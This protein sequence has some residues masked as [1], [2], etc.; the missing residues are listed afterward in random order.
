MNPLEERLNRLE[1][2]VTRY[3]NFNVLLCLL[4]VTVVT[5]A[6]R[7]G[8][9]PFQ[10]KS[11]SD[12]RA[13]PGANMGVPDS[14]DRG[15]PDV[16]YPEVQ[17]AG[18]LA[19]QT[20]GVIRTRRLEVVNS[21]GEAVVVLTP[22]TK[23]GGL[24][25]VNSA[26][27]KNLVYIGSSASN[28]NGLVLIN[29]TEEKN[30]IALASDSE[31]G[32]GYISI[33][34]RNEVRLLSLFAQEDNPRIHINNAEHRNLAYLGANTSG[35]GLLSLKNKSG[36][37]M[38]SVTAD[39]MSGHLSLMNNNDKTIAYLGTYSDYL[40][41]NSNGSGVLE[42]FSKNGTELITVG[43][44]T[45]DNGLVRGSNNIGTL[46]VALVAA[47]EQG[48]V[49]IQNS[50]ERLLVELTAT[51]VGDGLVRTLSK[52]GITTWSSA[53]FQGNTGS[54][55]LKGD[56]DNDGDIDGDDFLIFSE[57]FGK[58]E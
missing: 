50:Q 26:E 55:S 29:S 24:I 57:N 31:T 38:V 56:M 14:P 3:R 41:T 52:Q 25:F 35:N 12:P 15:V 7:E 19:A 16:M 43:S 13:M 30:L 32:D 34:N 48:Y 54:T 37:P 47:N 2:R 11:A 45:A 27:E 49:G 44:N 36:K 21:D 58:K 4:L 40:G 28:G 5:V 33:R 23:G 46:G 42:I 20:Q 6:A 9:S 8:V 18:K 53:S 17:V 1:M 39:D 22:S 51:P 10:A